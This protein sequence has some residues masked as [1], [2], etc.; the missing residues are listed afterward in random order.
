MSV[1]KSIVRRIEATAWMR[2][3]MK[4]DDVLRVLREKPS[5]REWLGISLILISYVI[6]WPAI[7]MLGVMAINFGEPLI[8][9]IGGPLSYGLSHLAFLAGLYLAGKRYVVALAQWASKKAL[10]RL[11]G[12]HN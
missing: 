8:L 1:L 5:L 12:E 7:A 10:T 2:T 4:N 6:G 3:V 9:A 11:T